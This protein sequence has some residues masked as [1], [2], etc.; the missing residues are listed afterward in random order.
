M[1][2]HKY[3]A[4]CHFDLAGGCRQ[5]YFK[6]YLRHK[7]SLSIEITQRRELELQLCTLRYDQLMPWQKKIVD[8]CNTTPHPRMVYWVVDEEGGRGKSV[9][10]KYLMENY[11]AFVSGEEARYQ[12][13][14][15]C[16]RLA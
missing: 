14:V 7:G 15:N 6:E 16:I 1:G 2:P 12:V 11:A 8:M 9:L 4:V 10:C 3:S 13:W 5:N